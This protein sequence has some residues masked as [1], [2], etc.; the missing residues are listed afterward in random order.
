MSSIEKLIKVDQENAEITR[1]L[2]YT[3]DKG[4]LNA[5][6]EGANLFETFMRCFGQQATDD[7]DQLAISDLSEKYKLGEDELL[8]LQ[9]K[10]NKD[11]CEKQIDEELKQI[12]AQFYCRRARSL[13]LMQ[14]YRS[15]MFAAAAIRRMS[16]ICALGQLRPEIEAVALMETFQSDNRLSEDWYNIKT[17]DQGT[18]FYRKTR[19]RV[20]EFCK[21]YDL[22]QEWNL[23]SA[24]AQHSRLVGIVG[25][26]KTN[27]FIEGDRQ[28]HEYKL[29]FQEIDQEKPEEYIVKA[30]YIL[31]TQAKLLLPIE[32]AL[33]EA[34]DPILRETR[35]PKFKKTIKGLYSVFG[36]K[37]PKF[38]AEFGTNH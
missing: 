35:I 32:I 13:L 24:A 36:Q 25:G 4:L 6:D 8:R 12:T 21:T 1:R 38:I 7:L 14:S 19:K 9:K 28:I 37:F 33:P 20:Y 2:F 5:F 22:E 3:F 34:S 27:D 17:N 29:A 31:R 30:L 23:S 26:L 10:E 16:F 15:F 18:A 11:S